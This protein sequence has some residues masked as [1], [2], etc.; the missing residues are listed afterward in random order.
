MLLL[1][2]KIGSA[3]LNRHV[4]LCTLEYSLS[5]EGGQNIYMY[6]IY[7]YI[8]ISRLYML[9]PFFLNNNNPHVRQERREQNNNGE[10]NRYQWVL[11]TGRDELWKRIIH[12]RRTILE[13]RYF[14]DKAR[15]TM[16]VYINMNGNKTDRRDFYGR[17]NREAGLNPHDF[18]KKFFDQALDALGIHSIWKPNLT[19]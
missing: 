7:I 13:R 4:I 16:V 18:R 12:Y 3:L 19:P 2:V 1:H 14:F 10:L 11:H 5:W 17:L 9:V 6:I 15:N 8:H